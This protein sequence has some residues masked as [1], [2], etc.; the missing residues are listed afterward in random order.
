L[1]VIWQP[2]TL[3]AH[4]K[5]QASLHGLYGGQNGAGTH[6]SQSISFSSV[7]IIPPVLHT[8]SLLSTMSYSLSSWQC[9]SVAHF[10]EKGH[11]FAI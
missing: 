10:V 5:S 3:K 2:L 9:H 4:V 1:A 8:D 7:S 11:I 6:S